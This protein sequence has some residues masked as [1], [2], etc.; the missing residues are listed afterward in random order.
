[1]SPSYVDFIYML[2]DDALISNLCCKFWRKQVSWWRK[3]NPFSFKNNLTVL[4]SDFSAV[5]LIL[6]KYSHVNIK[7]WGRMGMCVLW[8]SYSLSVEFSKCANM[9]EFKSWLRISEGAWEILLFTES[10]QMCFALYCQHLDNRGKH[11]RRRRT[12][13]NA[14]TFQK[15]G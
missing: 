15:C 4:R 7:P 1:M 3:Q 6:Y 5:L 8:E 14:K 2:I 12:M 13:S 11:Q 10:Q 9:Q